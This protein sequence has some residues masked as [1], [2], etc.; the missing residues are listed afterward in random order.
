MYELATIE[1]ILKRVDTVDN[2]HSTQFWL[3]MIQM[4]Q[5]NGLYICTKSDVK[6][7]AV[8]VFYNWHNEVLN[9]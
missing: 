8:D 7:T 6:Q 2:T 4:L 3:D 1:E 9:G 5:N